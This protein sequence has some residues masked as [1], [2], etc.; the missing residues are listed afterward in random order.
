MERDGDA[1]EEMSEGEEARV[2]RVT[3]MPSKEV[4]ENTHTNPSLLCENREDYAKIY[5]K[6]SMLHLRPKD[7][8]I[9]WHIKGYCFSNCPNAKHHKTL[10]AD[11]KSE[12]QAF[13]MRCTNQ[14]S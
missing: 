5:G 8:C 13:M 10:T 14:S 12:L 2:I 7:V 1:D 9:R 3:E 11:K 6:S 4:V